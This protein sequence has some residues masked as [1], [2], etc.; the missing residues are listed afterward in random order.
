MFAAAAVP[1]IPTQNK[2]VDQIHTYV[3]SNQDNHP[4][5]LFFNPITGEGTGF[6]GNSPASGAVFSFLAAKY[7]FMFFYCKT[8]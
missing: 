3:A 6:T 2:M 5:D 8:C 4:L 1:D 7:V